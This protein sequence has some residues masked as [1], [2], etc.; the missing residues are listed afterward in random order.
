MKTRK[1]INEMIREMS[2]TE[3]ARQLTQIN[4]VYLK[5]ESQAH[6]TGVKQNIGITREDMNDVCSILN[7][8][9]G[10]EM[11]E[12]QSKYLEE[13][14]QKIPLIFMQDV[15]HGYRTIFPIPLAMGATF[16]EKLVEACAEMSAREAKLNGVQVTF[17]P[18]VDLVRDPR[19][20]RVMET[21]SEDPYYNGEMGKAFVRGYHK[22]GL[23]CCV[24]HFAGYGAAEAGKDYNTTDLSEHMLREFYLRAYKECL[25]EE[26]EMVMSSFNML[27]GKPVNANHKL[28]ID[29]LRKEWVFDGIL[30]SDYNAIYEMIAHG[31]VETEK[32]CACI[33]ANNEIDIEMQSGTYI[34]H[35]AELV[36]EGKVPEETVNRMLRRVLE[37]KEKLGV[38]DD[39][40]VGV[41]YEEAKE[42]EL[43]EKH[44]NLA[45][46]AAEKSAV[47]LKNNGILPLQKETKIALIGPF[48]EEQD[49]LGAWFCFGKP[50]ETVSV[51]TG[52]EQFLGKHV[53]VSKGCEA[54]LLSED[55]SQIP[56][57]VK[58]A[59]K[60]D[61]IVMC[62]GEASMSSGE[63]ASRADLHIPYVQR[64]LLDELRKLEKPIVAVV[65]GGRPQ[66]L[67]DIENKLDAILYVWQPGT[68]GGNAIARLLYGE[69]NPSGKLPMTFPREMGQVP[70]Y[71]NHFQTGRPKAEDTLNCSFCTCSYRDVVN[72]PL[73]PF[74]Y[75]LSYTSF[76]V[77]NIILSTD[78][79]HKGET[80][81]ASVWVRNIGDC[82]GEEVIQLYIRDYF[83]SMIRPIKELK[84][85]QK[86]SLNPGEEIC[87]TFEITEKTLEFYDCNH[88]LK[89]EAGKFAIMIGTSSEQTEGKD[90]VYAG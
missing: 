87:V 55:F 66:I 2:V 18:M 6:L 53:I 19:W 77:S 72:A 3:K 70:V 65:F 27:N 31:Y 86:V 7:F 16:D 45:R 32:E 83:A 11:S 43:S 85:Y 71:Y 81:Q 15:I 17:S 54:D 75:G 44:R 35:L 37:L 48:A 13:S 82:A 28:L 34:K 30:I 47:L 69:V 22:G 49:I 59:E 23:G 62:I 73:Y 5:A 52:V 24:K 42:I 88:L 67:T 40:Y 21:T 80:M 78:T 56:Q 1:T 36:E 89:A 38:L 25:K 46:I 29:I 51:K 10:G 63:G 39:P 58:E 68:E 20:G 64:K 79:L 84:G 12:I 9:Y 76:E 57:A 26:P 60:A 61:V 74:G 41:D 33:A 90:F 50:E 14:H 4:A 8:M